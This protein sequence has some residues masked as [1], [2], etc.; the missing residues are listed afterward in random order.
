MQSLIQIHTKLTCISHTLHFF[1]QP[2]GISI[3]GPTNITVAATYADGWN[4]TASALSSTSFGVVVE[5]D[6]AG[7]PAPA[8]GIRAPGTGGDGGR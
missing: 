3:D 6:D 8:A 1:T 5:G 4:D 7:F 2:P